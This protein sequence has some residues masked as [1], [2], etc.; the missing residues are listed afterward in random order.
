MGTEFIAEMMRSLHKFAPTIPVPET[1]FKVT[2]EEKQLA[3]QLRLSIEK[4]GIELKGLMFD[5][6]FSDL[7]KSRKDMSD[8]FSSRSQPTIVDTSQSIIETTILPYFCRLKT[9][10]Q[11]FDLSGASVNF[12]WNCVS[13]SWQRLP[14]GSAHMEMLSMLF[15]MAVIHIKIA[16][17]K[18]QQGY[19]VMMKDF[20]SAAVY[21]TIAEQ[22]FLPELFRHSKDIDANQYVREEIS[23]LARVCKGQAHY[24]FFLSLIG[25]PAASSETPRVSPETMAGMAEGGALFFQE[26]DKDLGH[27]K[28]CASWKE[29]IKPHIQILKALGEMHL[30]MQHVMTSVN[31]GET[32][33]GEG[34]MRF[35]RA[36]EYLSVQCKA[37]WSA[38]EM[39]RLLEQCKDLEARARDKNVRIYH[40]PEFGGELPPKAKPLQG[41]PSDALYKEFEGDCAKLSIAN[42]WKDWLGV[43]VQ[44][45]LQQFESGCNTFV[46]RAKEKADML[47]KKSEDELAKAEVLSMLSMANSEGEET[48]PDSLQSQ[49]ASIQVQKAGTPAVDLLKGQF[50]HLIDRRTSLITD[51]TRAVDNLEAEARQDEEYRQQYGNRWNRDRSVE[52]HVHTVV[53]DSSVKYR[54]WLQGA[55]VQDRA[56]KQRVFEKEIV[57]RALD[58]DL[59]QIIAGFDSQPSQRAVG[60]VAAAAMKLSVL[61]KEHDDILERMNQNVAVLKD[62]P[63]RSRAQLAA[64]L[65][66][67]KDDPER[68]QGILGQA[69]DSYADQERSITSIFEAFEEKLGAVLT[70]TE[71]A[72]AIARKEFD[73]NSEK[74]QKILD[75]E[76]ACREFS[77]FSKRANSAVEDLKNV[78]SQISNLVG[79]MEAFTLSRREDAEFLEQGLRQQERQ[80]REREEQEALTQQYLAQQAQEAQAAE[81]ARRAEEQRRQEELTRQYLAQEAQAQQAQA[82]QFQPQQFQQFP[83]QQPAQQFYDPVQPAA[84]PSHPPGRTSPQH[85]A[86]WSCPMCTFFNEAANTSCEMCSTARPERF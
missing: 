86:G 67:A 61:K 85:S 76:Q 60:G 84:T 51:V 49:I 8:C 27:V 66:S 77:G 16:E 54:D 10:M 82:Q 46:Q 11:K 48:L 3:Q 59:S 28:S 62:L 19:R 12:P 1:A 15:N 18:R 45:Q 2:R 29:D 56:F 13:N 14:G 41:Q 83:P 44:M 79:H 43:E 34:I 68:T 40:H 22:E 58:T 73:K 35:K 17:T 50:T 6:F 75:L 74:Q 71:E 36:Q 4:S 47:S 53:K 55:L 7:E 38:G 52:H 24:C 21:L 32:Q 64:E 31:D 20:R 5:D 65:Q 39:K 30:G 81:Q 33:V 25:D 80:Q 37:K 23:T 70:A 9:V 78:D 42:P 72:K 26:L 63:Q 57:L 69:P